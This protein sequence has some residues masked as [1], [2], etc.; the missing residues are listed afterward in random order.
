M[1]NTPSVAE[2]AA[3]H[4]MH[5]FAAHHV[6]SATAEHIAQ[7]IQLGKQHAQAMARKDT[8]DFCHNGSV[9]AKANDRN[10]NEALWFKTEMTHLLQ[11]KNTV[12]VCWESLQAI[13]T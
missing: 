12:I 3:T 4:T 11:H 1:Q 13:F 2:T 10:N 7:G 5:D 6:Q 9:Y 8:A